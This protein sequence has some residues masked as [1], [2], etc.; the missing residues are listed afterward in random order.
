MHYRGNEDSIVEDFVEYCKWKTTDEAL[1]NT[2]VFDGTVLGKLCEAPSRVLNCVNEV[3]SQA[4]I[5]IVEEA[6]RL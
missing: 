4:G 5:L 1:A 2:C 6:G 3:C